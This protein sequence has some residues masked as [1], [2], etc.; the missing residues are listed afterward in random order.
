[1]SEARDEA[2]RGVFAAALTP[3]DGNLNVDREAF[4]LHCRRLLE[5]GCHGL[6]VFGTTG[7]ASSLSAKERAAALEALVEA[8]IPGERLLPGTGSCA[9]TEAVWLSRAALEAGAAGVLVLPPFY[10]KGVTDEGLYR[11]FAQLIERVGDGRLRLYLY[12]FPQMTGGVGISV[13]LVRRLAADYPEVVRGIKD[14]EGSWPRIEALC[15]ELPGFGVFA[16]TERFLLDTLRA[17]GAGCISATANVTARLARRVYDLHAAGEPGEASSAQR[18][19]TGLRKALEAYPAIPAL[20]LLMRDLTGEDRWL[21][22][23]P[24][25]VNLEGESAA[26]L[27]E[28]ARTLGLAEHAP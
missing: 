16:G 5:A 6:G 15:R 10:Y 11:F 22:L 14:S 28:E 25:L 20:K 1:M 19:L 26:R 8:G 2:P 12:H 9:L 27:L 3:M 24:P 7:E 17:G 21:N 4:A 18:R 13:P 23:R